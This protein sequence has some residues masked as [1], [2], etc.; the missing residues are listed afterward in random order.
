MTQTEKLLMAIKLHAKAYA[1]GK[2]LVS[3][4]EY[5]ELVK[6][7]NDEIGSPISRE[8]SDLVIPAVVGSGVEVTKSKRIVF[9]RPMLSLD[10]AFDE[11]Q[12]QEGVNRILRKMMG[13][14]VE[15]AAELKID[16]IAIACCYQNGRLIWAAVRGD[17][18]IG[19]NVLTAAR[20]MADLPFSIPVDSGTVIVTGEAY[21]R[22]SDFILLN[23]ERQEA[24]L[25]EYASPRN[26][27]AGAFQHTDPEEVARRQIRF[28]A[29]GILHGRDPEIVTG[30]QETRWFSKMGFKGIEWGSHRLK[31]V[32]Q[33]EGMFKDLE[34]R[35]PLVDYPCDGVVIKMES[36]AAREIVGQSST[37]PHW[38][39]ACKLEAQRAHSFLDDVV[40]Q[41]GRTG[42]VTPVAEV[43]PVVVGDVTVRRITLHNKDFIE[44]L[45]L[46]LGDEIVIKRAGDVIPAV[47]SVETR[48]RTGTET[49][50]KFPSLCPECQTPLYRQEGEARIY[51]PN[52][53]GCRGQLQRIIEFWS[54]REYMYL[55]GIG[56][57][58]IEQLMQRG[59][60]KG[61]P[62]L[63]RLR[64]EDL[65]VLDGFKERKVQNFLGAVDES[66]RRPLSRL[67]ASLGIREIGRSAS[68][69]I[70]GRYKTMDAIMELTAG[71]KPKAER[72]EGEGAPECIR[73]MMSFE[74]FGERMAES[75]CLY[76][77]NEGN[78]SQIEELAS[79]G[80]NMSE[81]EPA[82]AA[83]SV[84]SGIAAMPLAGMNVCATGKLF[85][86]NRNSIN[87]RI[88]ELGG[89]P[90]SS[91]SAK[92]NLLIVGEK[93][94]S[95]L[96]KA[97][98]LGIKVV[99]E[100]EFEAMCR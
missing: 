60:V 70:T 23:Q 96:Q 44:R 6:E 1:E 66:R 75:F 94:G 88:S 73:E 48:T 32:E 12:R 39:F 71:Y 51:C 78:R 89:L 82:V 86:Y 52:S 41:V 77:A 47:E 40:F 74:G 16:G 53:L 98:K 43:K 37:S 93:A 76:M 99:T 38:A 61:I 22:F 57:K 14:D 63:Y 28:F 3:D 8:A 20:H 15:F 97:R 95:K 17:G 34:E 21:M 33:V 64:T 36:M 2:P 84:S 56:P 25:D 26:T 55:D 65:Q 80:L 83:A 11:A 87:D 35:I 29:H 45:D 31:T 85:G 67:L 79:L 5:D 9:P 46:R 90:Q 7:Y 49:A 72:D 10:N 50:V 100:T 91:V 27:V 19:E 62:D 59:L 18:T 58:Q 68:R 92:T 81:P 13:R 69:Q 54:G 4:Q 24:G 42:A 30:W